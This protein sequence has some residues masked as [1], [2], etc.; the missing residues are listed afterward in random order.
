MSTTNSSVWIV[1]RVTLEET[2][3]PGPWVKRAACAGMP[4]DWFFPDDPADSETARAVCRPC[5]VRYDCA[6]YALAVPGIGGI[7]GGLSETDRRRLRRCEGALSQK[8]MLA[9]AFR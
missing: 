6:A 8:Q 3:A 2:P 4:T 9:A 5:P 7:W 1:S